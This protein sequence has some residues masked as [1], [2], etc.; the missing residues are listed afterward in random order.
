MLFVW[1]LH[2]IPHEPVQK[3]SGF[4][5]NGAETVAR[6]QGVHVCIVTKTGHGSVYIRGCEG[7][8]YQYGAA[9]DQFGI[10]K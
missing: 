3:M 7:I 5:N 10:E 1:K 4:H 9:P 6:R 2:H 8:M